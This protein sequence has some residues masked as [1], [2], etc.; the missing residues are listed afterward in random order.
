MNEK[1]SKLKEKLVL[2]F[3]LD[4]CEIEDMELFTRRLEVL[5]EL[6][7]LLVEEVESL[8]FVRAVNIRRGINLHEEMR[9]F[10]IH[11]VQSALERTGGH[12]TKAAAL[13]GISLT[14]LHNK[15][16]RLNISPDN[17]INAPVFHED[18]VSEIQN[19]KFGA[20][21]LNREPRNN[22]VKNFV[23]RKTG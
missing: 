1:K 19:T 7:L 17:L 8:G 13:L 20:N 3:S 9:R 4:E 16:K 15:L 6:A 2:L 10:E 14:T 22:Q 18:K 5:K 11:L 12:Q 23:L 21:S